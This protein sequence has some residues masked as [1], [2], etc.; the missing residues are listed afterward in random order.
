MTTLESFCQKWKRH[1]WI[2]RHMVPWV[3]LN[4]YFIHSSPVSYCPGVGK[5]QSKENPRCCIWRGAAAQRLPWPNPKPLSVTISIMVRPPSVLLSPARARTWQTGIDHKV[6]RTMKFVSLK[7][8]GLHAAH[9]LG[10]RA[11]RPLGQPVEAK[12]CSKHGQQSSSQTLT[13][14]HAEPVA[15]ILLHLRTSW[16]SAKVYL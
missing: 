8:S 10:Y 11:H 6:A 15:R 2:K 16:T 4:A 14:Q 12:S 3:P 7:W 13:I 1:Q 5:A 9:K